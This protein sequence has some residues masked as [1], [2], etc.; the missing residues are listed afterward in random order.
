MDR[1]CVRLNMYLVIYRK[2]KTGVPL[3]GPLYT[4][5]LVLY[6]LNILYITLYYACNVS[7]VVLL[8]K[9]SIETKAPHVRCKNSPACTKSYTKLKIRREPTSTGVL[10]PYP[11]EGKKIEEQKGYELEVCGNAFQTPIPSHS[12]RA[13]GAGPLSER[14]GIGGVISLDIGRCIKGIENRK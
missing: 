12:H 9:S 2:I 10:P 13:S 3:F 5:Y 1:L 8:Y 4:L 14:Y 6:K 7:F 11:S